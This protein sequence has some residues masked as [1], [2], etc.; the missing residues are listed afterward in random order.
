MKKLPKYLAIIGLSMMILGAFS[1]SKVEAATSVYYSDFQGG[2]IQA[3]AQTVLGN[4]SVSQTLPISTGLITATFFNASSTPI[5]FSGSPQIVVA[6][7]TPTTNAHATGLFTTCNGQTI[8][9]GSFIQCSGVI[10]GANGNTHWLPGFTYWVM[11]DDPQTSDPGLVYI[12]DTTRTLFTGVITDGEGT[13]PGWIPGLTQSGIASS[14]LRQ[15]CNTSFATTTGFFDS[16]T[17]SVTNGLCNV[18]VFLF[19]PNQTSLSQW[20]D[21]AS[22]SQSKIPF[23][24]Y[25]D[26]RIILNG[27]HASSSVNFPEFGITGTNW[28]IGSTTPIGNLVPDFTYLSSTTISKYMPNGMYELMFLLMR[29]AIWIWVLFHIYRRIVPKHTTHV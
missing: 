3:D 17:S 19:V 8:N 2:V 5:T 21:L 7:T 18:V 29:S 15:F 23:S 26:V 28:G 20:R 4:F 1:V 22:T 14:T 16:L 24:Y 12:S 10:N 27:G 9:P 11:N 25:Y 13:E 6:T